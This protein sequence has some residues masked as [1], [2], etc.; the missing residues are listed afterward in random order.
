[1]HL[2]ITM[3]LSMHKVKHLAMVNTVKSTI[4]T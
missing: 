2:H 1:M 3:Y 4:D